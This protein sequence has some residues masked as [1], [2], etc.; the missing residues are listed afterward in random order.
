MFDN[1]SSAKRG[2]PARARMPT[3]GRQPQHLKK[4]KSQQQK[5]PPQQGHQ[6]QTERLNRKGSQAIAS[7][8]WDAN[9]SMDTSN[10]RK[11]D[12]SSIRKGR[13]GK[14][15]ILCQASQ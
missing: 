13:S 6:Q 8:R 3:A 9:N 1:G 15:A 11:V 14:K 10:N 4:K 7:N 2:T 5:G 12:S